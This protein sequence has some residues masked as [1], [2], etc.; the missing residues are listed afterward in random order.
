MAIKLRV[1]L[2]CIFLFFWERV[3]REILYIL[4]KLHK[5]APTKNLHL[6]YKCIDKCRRTEKLINQNGTL[7]PL[8]TRHRRN[9]PVSN[10]AIPFSLP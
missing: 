9:F 5:P 6:N 1:I 8:I 7:E 10:R 4:N 3:V 2:S